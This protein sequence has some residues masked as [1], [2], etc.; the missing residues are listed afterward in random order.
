MKHTKTKLMWH[1]INLGFTEVRNLQ[2]HISYSK[3]ITKEERTRRLKLANTL[4][5]LE[6]NLTDN[7]KKQQYELLKCELMNYMTKLLKV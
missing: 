4:K 1:P 2:V 6:N 3:A 7:L 5:I